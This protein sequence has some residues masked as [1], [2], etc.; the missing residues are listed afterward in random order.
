[1]GRMRDDREPFVHK[2]ENMPA[3]YRFDRLELAGSL[4]DLGTLLPLAIGMILVNGMSV[5]GIFFSVGL[6]YILAGV[7]FGVPVP[8]QPMKAIGAYSIATGM[9]S[10]QVAG[11]TFLV[12]L[13]LFL[14]G[15]T[16]L[17]EI[18]GKIIPKP[19]IRGVQLSTGLLLMNQGVNMI[20][21]TS[22]H[23]LK[24]GAIEPYLTVQ[25]LGPLPVGL[26]LGMLGM[27]VTLF[28]L[29]NKRYPAAIIVLALGLAAGA[30]WGTH[31]GF[32]G[33]V[34]G[35]YTPEFLPFGFPGSADLTV[36]LFVLVLPQIPM[37]V[38]NAIIAN[39]DLSREYFPEGAARVTYRNTTL[40]MS[41][42]N[43]LSFLV[44][45]I[46]LCHGAGGLAAHYQFGARTGGSNI[47][48]GALFLLLGLLFGPHTLAVIHL[49][50]FSV[51]GVLLIFAGGQ[52]GL[53]IL[54][55]YNRKN[56][57]LI[58]GMVSVT[59]TTNLA[60]GFVTGV[61]LAH[62]LRSEKITV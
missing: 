13:L 23:Q 26:L 42:A 28:L 14:V 61:V 18:I 30:V 56:L 15:I 34:P 38:G 8:V 44:G 57:F 19:V 24:S 6:F 33:L 5:T 47:I 7:Y 22:P 41:V 9:S 46:P 62:L 10:S 45:G 2:V 60:W 53:T 50:P 48:I 36:A 3:K 16:G 11:S 12:C 27:I 35:F 37:T 39:A 31:E 43:L 49:L 55:M 40:S 52:L 59:L 58:L 1:M 25:H 29:H 32:G 21:G 17:I 20:L 4:G 54:D 51:L